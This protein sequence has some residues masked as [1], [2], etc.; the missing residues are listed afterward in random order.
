MKIIIVGDSHT[1]AWK[2]ARLL[3]TPAKCHELDI[4]LC[5]RSGTSAMGL[6]NDS[7][8][9]KSGFRWR[10]F[11]ASNA[12]KAEALVVQVGGV[13]LDYIYFYKLHNSIGEKWT[14]EKQIEISIRGISTWLR[15][16]RNERPSRV[17]LVGVQ[18][19]VLPTPE[20]VKRS[21]AIAAKKSAHSQEAYLNV[22]EFEVLSHRE[23]TEATKAYNLKLQQLAKSLGFLYL[24][25][26]DKLINEETGVVC[27]EF[28]DPSRVAA[29]DVHLSE[30]ATAPLYMRQLRNILWDENIIAST[31]NYGMGATS[32]SETITLPKKRRKS[33]KL[34]IHGNTV[35]A[36]IDDVN[37][38]VII[39]KQNGE[40]K[41]YLNS[42]RDTR[43]V[44]NSNPLDTTRKRPRIHK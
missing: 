18:P 10:R 32:S 42:N 7:S 26:S 34:R 6:C 28:L 25:I 8:K 31:S 21:L 24:E 29:A 22:T 17:V 15:S 3:P 2:L 35:R 39:P 33:R 41:K 19:P 37:N 30:E 40:H 16:L 20:L 27:E 1:D 4:V 12:K 23:R 38:R 43:K 44:Y 5:R 14:Y 11:I 36:Y 9:T 13:D